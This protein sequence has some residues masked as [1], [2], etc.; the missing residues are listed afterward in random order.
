MNIHNLMS[1]LSIG[2]KSRSNSNNAR[3]HSPNQDQT[4]VFNISNAGGGAGGG[5]FAVH[6]INQTVIS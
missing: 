1:R 3:I 6:V 5:G 2:S 4:P